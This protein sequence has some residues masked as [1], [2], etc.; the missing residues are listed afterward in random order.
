MIDAGLFAE[1][2][3]DRGFG[4]YAGV[5]CS[6]LKPFINF[7]ID[8]PGSD[9]IAAANEG[10]AVAIGAGAYLG[11]RPA[12]VMFQNSGLGN[13]VN[14][15]TSLTYTSRIPLLLI[16]TLRG[17]PAGDADEPQHL[18]MGRITRDMFQLLE[19]PSEPFPEDEQ[20]V[21]PTLD[22]ALAHM[23]SER[24]PYALIMRKGAVQSR[25][26]ES[27]PVE[28]PWQHQPG[29]PM[30]PTTRRRDYL[31]AVLG[32]SKPA[33]A[34][35]ATTGY[36]GRELYAIEDRP[37]SFYM[38]GSMGCAASIG[39]GL[40]LARPD[41]R[42]IVL[43]GDGALLM[44]LGALATA[45][46][47]RPANLLHIVL[48]NG[49]HESTGGQA[50]VSRSL[51]LSAMATAC[52][53]R[54]AL[55]ISAPEDLAGVVGSAITGPVFVRIP[56]RPGVPANLPRPAMSP[57]DVAERFRRHLGSSDAETSAAS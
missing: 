15:L 25:D 38:V 12:V 17:D 55:D 5:P 16:V 26:L 10:D 21:G 24:R 37:S 33:D 7:V 42:V 31:A 36:T 11:G 54:E 22:R 6:Y 53:Y 28:Q 35:I 48:D 14:P 29:K 20:S 51:D 4:L 2:A 3:R 41:R 32:A 50:T 23:K 30:A 47:Y 9:Y 45:G 46:H 52:G 8:D 40:A 44:R 39:M 57:V 49:L 18:L 19:I 56:V 1:A 43:D 34:L 13:A 27:S